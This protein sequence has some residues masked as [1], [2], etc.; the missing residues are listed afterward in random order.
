MTL[1]NWRNQMKQNLNKQWTKSTL[2]RI[3]S[4]F[5]LELK[6]IWTN[7]GENS[8]C[9]LNFKSYFTCY[10]YIF[11]IYRNMY[12]IIIYYSVDLFT[13]T[14]TRFSFRLKC[15]ALSVEPI[16]YITHSKRLIDEIKL[17]EGWKYK[18]YWI[19]LRKTCQICS[20]DTHVIDCWKWLN[21]M[22][23][24]SIFNF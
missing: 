2:Q 22:D 5:V 16:D 14:L 18:T 11:L 21:S 3:T 9:V 4:R 7:H 1:E 8:F 19:W 24:I 13:N 6:L 10:V 20:L 23:A 17:L 12:I 15:T